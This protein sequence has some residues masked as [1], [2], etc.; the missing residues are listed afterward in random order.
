MLVNLRLQACLDGV[1]RLQV[2][3]GGPVLVV[4][5][6]RDLAGQCRVWLDVDEFGQNVQFWCKRAS[7][8]V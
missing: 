5:V 4:C 7:I 2:S 3:V 8:F 6:V 1:I